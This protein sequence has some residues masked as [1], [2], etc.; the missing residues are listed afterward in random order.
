MIKKSFT[1]EPHWSHGVASRISFEN[2]DF[3]AGLR[4]MFGAKDHEEIAAIEI[5]EDGIQAFFENKISR[6][7]PSA[8]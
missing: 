7:I 5:T 1:G 3:M 6:D 8:R 2:E 4:Q